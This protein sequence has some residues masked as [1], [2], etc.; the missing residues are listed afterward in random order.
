MT[1]FKKHLSFKIFTNL[2]KI[3]INLVL[4]AIFPRLLGP[5]AYGNFDFLQDSASKI[6][7]FFDTGSSIAFYTRLSQDYTNHK[8]IKFYWVIV[9]ALCCLYAIFV[10][11]TKLFGFSDSVWPKQEFLMIVLSSVLGIVTFI[12][13]TLILI[14]DAANLTVGAEKVRMFH[15][16]ISVLVYGGVLWFFQSTLLSTF[17]LIQIFLIV[18]LIAG[19]FWVLYT[20]NVSIFTKDSLTMSDIKVYINYFWKFSNPLLVYSLVGLLTGIGA[21]WILQQFGGAIQQAYFG[22]SAKIGGFVLLFSSA[23][24]P[25][26]IREFSRLFAQ[27][28]QQNLKRLFVLSYKV[29]YVIS[30]F[31]ALFVFFNAAII[32]DFLGGKQFQEAV[33]VLSIMAFF[34]VHQS[35]GQI[36]G[37]FFYS[38]NRNIYHRN[39]GLFF[40]PLSLVISFFFIAPKEYFGLDLGAEGLALQMVLVQLLTVNVSSYVNSRFLKI[41]YLPLL[42]YQVIVFILFYFAGYL[43]Y[44]CSSIITE[45]SFFE[46]FIF[47]S[48]FTTIIG[49]LLFIFPILSGFKTRAEFIEL[50]P[51]RWKK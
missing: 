48:I 24:M 50:M 31:I 6:I 47:I 39:I 4:N 18:L 32:T 46:I 27:S 36:N 40:M 30:M 21:R 1:E 45:N 19:C 34:P 25:L 22:L 41:A 5:V 14:T 49:G 33:A 2:L 37:S 51:F 15:M 38:T 17:F 13:S 44:L 9:A 29:L 20:S 28:N 42:F 35:L 11:S 43:S 23:L 8:L 10:I 12:S 26:I 16:L 3:P 7:G